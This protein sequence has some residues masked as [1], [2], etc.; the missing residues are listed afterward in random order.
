MRL[1][2]KHSLMPDS[3]LAEGETSW[4]A[5]TSQSTCEVQLHGRQGGGTLRFSPRT[6]SGA[7]RQLPWHVQ[8]RCHLE[9]RSRADPDAEFCW[10]QHEACHAASA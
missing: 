5:V 9:H 4:E 10:L 8:P 3:V 7:S 6:E 2:Q 1:Y